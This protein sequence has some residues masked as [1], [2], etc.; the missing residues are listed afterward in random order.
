VFDRYT[1]D[2]LLPLPLPLPRTGSLRWLKVAYFRVLAY[3]A[4][5]PDLVLVLDAP[6][7]V[8]FRRTGESTPDRLEEERRVFLRL[9]ERLGAQRVDASRPLDAVCAD[10]TAAIWRRYGQRSTVSGAVGGAVGAGR[11]DVVAPVD[12][13]VS[14]DAARSAVKTVLRSGTPEGGWP[15]SSQP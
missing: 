12:F 2:A 15:P 5:R 3:I 4:P 8:A 13:L 1:Y 14:S 11:E 7:A 9:V 6:G 10:V